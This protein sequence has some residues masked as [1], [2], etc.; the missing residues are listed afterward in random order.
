M[1]Q[2]KI[3]TLLYLGKGLSHKLQH[4]TQRT[5]SSLSLVTLIAMMK[6]TM[7]MVKRQWT[8]TMTLKMIFDKYK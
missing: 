4:Q 2:I 5:Q 8:N 6:K 3:Q 1:M 7:R